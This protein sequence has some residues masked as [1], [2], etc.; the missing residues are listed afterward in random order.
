MDLPPRLTSLDRDTFLTFCD[1]YNHYQ[2]RGGR[3][4]PSELVERH[5]RE[6]IQYAVPEAVKGDP[7]QYLT[8]VSVLI[9]P[10]SRHNI[11]DELK[12]HKLSICSVEEVLKYQSK[13]I[14]TMRL[15]KPEEFA[16]E[17]LVKLFIN[18]ITHRRLRD[19]VIAYSPDSLP[20]AGQTL[21]REA[22]ILSE[23]E[24]EARAMLRPEKAQSNQRQPFKP[25]PKP[26]TFNAAKANTSTTTASPNAARSPKENRSP[27][28]QK[29]RRSEPFV[30]AAPS[31]QPQ[32]KKPTCYSCGV[33]GHVSPNCPNKQTSP[34]M[35]IK[36]FNRDS[37]PRV[38]LT[39]HGPRGSLEVK[40][41]IDTASSH[42]FVK[43]SLAPKL[44]AIGLLPKEQFGSVY[45]ANEQLLSFNKVF[46]LHVTLSS[47]P[48]TRYPMDAAILDVGEELL[49]GFPWM[50]E[51]QLISDLCAL[52]DAI[53]RASVKPTLISEPPPAPANPPDTA[54]DV[55]FPLDPVEPH[56]APKQ[57]PEV[58]SKVIQDFPHVFSDEL[59][60]E[61]ARVTP[62]E[63]QLAPGTSPQPVPPR[64]LAPSRRA[65]VTKEVQRL[66]KE[67]IIRPSTSPYAA[68]IV[69][70]PK[71]NGET[72]M[73]VDY[74]RLNEITLAMKFP[75]AN[76]RDC[77][78][79]LSGSRYFCTLD[80]KS[81]FH[82]MPLHPESIPL[83]AFVTPDGLYEFLRVPFGL[84]NASSYFQ[85]TMSELLSG[86]LHHGVEVF[87]DDICIHAPTWQLLA[88]RLRNVLKRLANANLVLRADKCK[89]GLE[90]VHF[91]GHVVNA[92]GISMD[93]ER[94]KG[95][96]AMKPPASATDL[97][98]FLGAVNFCRPFLKNLGPLTKPLHTAASAKR[99]SWTPN[100]QKAFDEVK[101]L[102]ANA[103]TLAFIDYDKPI[104]LRTDASLRGV[105]AVLYQLNDSN[106]P[107]YIAF[108]SHAFSATESRWSTIEQEAY[109]VYF[110][111][112]S[113]EPYLL[114]QH[115]IVETDH[116]NLTYINKATAPKIVRWRLRLQDYDFEI[117]HVAGTDNILADALSRCLKTDSN[118]PLPDELINEFK[119]Y[120]NAVI[121]HN[122]ISR[123]FA[124]AKSSQ[125]SLS[126]SDVRRLVAACPTC[127]KLRNPPD[128]SNLPLRT[129]SVNAPFEQLSIDYIGPLPMDDQ[130]N[131]YV[132]VAI[133]SFTRFI[134]L[135]A[136]PA[137]TAQAAASFLLELFGRY[138][139]PS[140]L[141]SDQGTHFTAAVIRSLCAATGVEQHLTTPYRPE[142][143]GTVERAN[144][145]V[146]RHLRAL[147]FDGSPKTSWSSLLPIVQRIINA[148]PHSSTGF[149]P[150]KLLFSGRVN[151]NR[152]LLTT[153]PHEE[154]GMEWNDLFQ[155]QKQL[156]ALAQK[157][158]TSAVEQRLSKNPPNPPSFALNTLVLMSY[159]NRPPSKLSPVWRGPLIVRGVSGDSYTLEDV[160][161]KK[162]VRCHLSRLKQYDNS[163]DK[164]PR[165]I[166]A[167]DTDELVV[168]AIV[169]HRKTRKG[170]EFRVRWL[171]YEPSED[172][173]EP[174][175]VV[176]DLAA[177]DHYENLTGINFSKRGR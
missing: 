43:P 20:I 58:I 18:G 102:L 9:A 37:L 75:L 52:S 93:P 23:V 132:L 133:D 91:L 165:T 44:K 127:Q 99:F 159:P 35:K 156:L 106:L 34:L 147:L 100:L 94:V 83:T 121:G 69:L 141:R 29:P 85:K 144:A 1:D 162:L 90:E 51:H 107:C 143:N 53:K 161:S 167:M 171:G 104:Y 173:W 68:P 92:N 46:S 118:K 119:K 65:I 169:D 12:S 174:Y 77:L 172:T 145:E 13:W 175:S 49:L 82:Q 148:T 155:A 176:K 131:K 84:K 64:R 40:A 21:L 2:L 32:R 63:L 163:L 41:L 24:R 139:A 130:N 16:Q 36:C 154:E 151:L 73:C 96:L 136:T 86:L 168:E 61:P 137:P 54:A 122:G 27:N 116:K 5:I 47:K 7:E 42:C 166:A 89:F 26:A 71:K 56:V 157:H 17:L 39:I 105:G 146:L 88:E 66:L 4:H 67:N 98:T 25:Y 19:R 55:P 142:S 113:F 10:M 177:L 45:T 72:R 135:R 48:D 117:R 120:H 81:G 125:S 28:E 124:F 70:V 110:G 57:I 95:L 38:V 111:I 150:A 160:N 59:P 33:V 129:T 126:R 8:A 31:S 108:A 152:E 50:H 79:R 140:V 149:A 80:L 115:F 109:A 74:R 112:T 14:K 134:E 97:R 128:K 123:T 6:A 3:I 62:M 30:T 78:D 11:I 170:L 60:I 76:V 22:R 103:P 101:Q 158:Q 153:L 138:G 87:I 114:G 164:D 15:G